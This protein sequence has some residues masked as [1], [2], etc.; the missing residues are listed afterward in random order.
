MLASG[1]KVVVVDWLRDNEPGGP[2][3]EMLASEEEITAT[4]ERTGF[5]NVATHSG[6]ARHCLITAVK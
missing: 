1:Q 4:L 3:Q 6:P 5:K 2:P